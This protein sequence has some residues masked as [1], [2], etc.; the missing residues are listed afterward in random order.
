[1]V[2]ERMVLLRQALMIVTE[3]EVLTL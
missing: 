2:C 3:M 1:M